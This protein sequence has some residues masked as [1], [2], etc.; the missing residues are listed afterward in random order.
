V[1]A[2]PCVCS[3]RQGQAASEE[4]EDDDGDD[5]DDEQGPGAGGAVRSVDLYTGIAVE[6]SFSGTGETRTMT[7]LSGGQ[8][9]VVA[10]ALIF[11]I[12]RCDPAP[13]YLLDEI[14]QALDSTHRQAVAALIHKQATAVEGTTQFI[15]STFYP[16]S[17]QVAA[18]CYGV[19]CRNKVSHVHALDRGEALEFIKDIGAP[20]PSD[21][22]PAP[23]PAPG[24]GPATP[25][26]E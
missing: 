20:E 11:A 24:G 10:L 22:D 13:F 18:Q 15:T 14:D 9:A 6:V 8:K 7:R 26:R 12:Q 2:P 16:E 4:D 1:A 21:K 23:S 17:V 19:V 25:D 3:W 5:D